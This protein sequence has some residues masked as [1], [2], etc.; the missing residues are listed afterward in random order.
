M[1][2]AIILGASALVLAGCQTAEQSMVNAES[3]CLETGLKPGTGAYARCK[4]AGYRQNVAQSDAAA[5]QAMAGAAV[6]VIGRRR[7]LAGRTRRR[8]GAYRHPAGAPSFV[9][10]L[11]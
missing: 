4:N 8:K 2:L 11:S 10:A 5:G 6:G 7:G 1:R 3:V 9:S